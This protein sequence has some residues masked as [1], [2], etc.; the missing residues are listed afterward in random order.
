MSTT[1]GSPNPCHFLWPAGR[2]LHLTPAL[3][4]NPQRVVLTLADPNSGAVAYLNPIT[5]DPGTYTLSTIGCGPLPATTPA[6]Y[7]TSPTYHAEIDPTA[8]ALAHIDWLPSTLSSS[9]PPGYHVCDIHSILQHGGVVGLRFTVQRRFIFDALGPTPTATPTATP[10]P[11]PVPMTVLVYPDLPGS[12]TDRPGTAYQRYVNGQPV[13]QDGA[14]G[15]GPFVV[16]PPDPAPSPLILVPDGQATGYYATGAGTCHSDP[17]P[18]ATPHTVLVYVTPTPGPTQTPTPIPPTLTPGPSPT[19]PASSM[20]PTPPPAP[21]ANPF[22]PC[23]PDCAAAPPP[24][25]WLTPAPHGTPATGSLV[26]GVMRTAVAASI[27]G[28][29]ITP[30]PHASDAQCQDTGGGAP[31]LLA[32]YEVLITLPV[33][34]TQVLTYSLVLKQEVPSS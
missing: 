32:C 19:W 10:S 14:P 27:P 7:A 21:P 3:D 24:A 28:A 25:A 31:T 5:I 23:P 9:A 22:H 4:D 11:Q 2:P 20:M 30:H 16:C 13:H 33:T 29:I 15:D 26:V 8:S 34:Q 18:T 6:P 17:A 1:W 12:P